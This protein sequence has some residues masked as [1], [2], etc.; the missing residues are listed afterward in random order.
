VSCLLTS[1]DVALQLAIKTNDIKD[2]I[3]IYTNQYLL[4]ATH[5]ITSPPNH[6]PATHRNDNNYNKIVIQVPVKDNLQIMF[7]YGFG[8]WSDEVI[9]NY[10][11]NIDSIIIKNRH[12]KFELNN[13]TAIETYLK[14]RRK[15]IFRNVM[16]IKSNYKK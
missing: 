7:L 2:S 15:G 10:S 12:G 5:R 3:T 6:F 11:S 8:Y 1:C 4:P 14:S 13:R 16:S 9:S